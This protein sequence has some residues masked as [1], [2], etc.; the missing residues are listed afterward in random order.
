LSIA[1]EV[2]FFGV[3]Q[4]DIARKQCAIANSQLSIADGP[5]DSAAVGGAKP[6]RQLTFGVKQLANANRQPDRGTGQLIRADRQLTIAT[7][8]LIIDKEQLAGG[9]DGTVS[10]AAGTE[11]FDTPLSNGKEKVLEEEC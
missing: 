5:A 8:Q 1:R 6:L 10:G 2:L 7:R 11:I 3:S 9:S 4:P